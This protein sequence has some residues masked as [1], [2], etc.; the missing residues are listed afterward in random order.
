MS[1]DFD[2]E[3]EEDFDEEAEV[4]PEAP[5][6][7]RIAFDKA[8][9]SELEEDPAKMAM[10]TAGA[11]FKNVTRLFNQYMID[12]GRQMSKADKDVVLDKFLNDAHLEDEEGFTDAVL[13]VVTN[14][15]GASDKSA[16]SMIRAWAKKK[17]VEVYK[18]PKGEGLVRNP[19]LTNFFNALIENP[20]MDADGLESILAALEPQQQVNPR[21]W[22]SSHNNVRKMV[23]TIAAKFA[24]E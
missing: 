2:V 7:I 1:E 12:S 15:T 24:D 9:D 10:I 4:T 22:I 21:R 13:I 23:N 19:F 18:R 17:E 8:M 16:A 6:E 3:F 14:V 20:S 11:S 5:D